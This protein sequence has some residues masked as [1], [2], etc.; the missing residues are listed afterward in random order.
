MYVLMEVL[1][2]FFSICAWQSVTK[3]HTDKPSQLERWLQELAKLIVI[4]QG[5]IFMVTTKQESVLLLWTVLKIILLMFIQHFVKINV[6]TTTNLEIIQRKNAKQVVRLGLNKIRRK[7]V[8]QLALLQIIMM[9]HSM[10][11]L[12]QHFAW[13]NVQLIHMQTIK[14]TENVLLHALLHLLKP[15]GLTKFVYLIVHL[16]HG[17][18]LSMLI[19]FVLPVVQMMEAHKVMDTTV[20]ES[21]CKSALILNTVLL[22]QQFQFVFLRVKPGL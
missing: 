19:G 1:L 18:I 7:C 11:I 4:L 13:N 2:I 8:W 17:L 12:L 15:M 16:Q 3:H 9:R 6:H 5:M 14:Q 21:V 22:F 10:E 20:L